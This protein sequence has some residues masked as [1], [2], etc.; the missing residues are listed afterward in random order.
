MRTDVPM[1]AF[2]TQGRH[3]EFLVI[4][5]WA[6]SCP[7]YLKNTNE[8]YF[9]FV[10]EDVY[11]TIHR[12]HIRIQPKHGMDTNKKHLHV[13]FDVL[14]DNLSLFFSKGDES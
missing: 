11:L 9:Q 12:Q 6:T 4:L 10:L 5:F 13:M 2:R 1:I 7:S 8:P 14:R 3:D